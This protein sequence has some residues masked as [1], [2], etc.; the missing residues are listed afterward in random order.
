MKAHK[1]TV[2]NGR[3]Y[4]E[5]VKH[6]WETNQNSPD[7]LI[8]KA[9]ALIEGVDGKI[10]GSAIIEQLGKVAFMLAFQIGQEQFKL[11]WPVLEPKNPKKMKSA[12]RQAA[13]AL[14]H[15]VKALVVL[16]KF[17]D[18]KFAFGHYLLLKDGRT[19]GEVVDSGAFERLPM[20]L[21]AGE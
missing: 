2:T 4:A 17:F 1:A 14:L 16:A 20:L 10:L 3:K 21:K 9:K 6:Y 7:T 15:H 19:V 11:I 5:D 8:D 13:T 12:K 18:A